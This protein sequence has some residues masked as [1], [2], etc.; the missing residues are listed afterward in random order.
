MKINVINTSNRLGPPSVFLAQFL[1]F[2]T[3]LY[4][5]SAINRNDQ[6]IKKNFLNL[7]ENDPYIAMFPKTKPVD[8][9]DNV[10][11]M[12]TKFFFNMITLFNLFMWTAMMMMKNQI[13]PKDPTLINYSSFV[14]LTRFLMLRFIHQKSLKQFFFHFS[15]ED[16]LAIEQ[17]KYRKV[18]RENF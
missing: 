12:A 1:H 2:R 4:G 9:L 14:Y 13:G 10:Q 5:Q 16:K 3:C 8:Y 18:K 15:R 7:F 11:S 17:Q 6:N